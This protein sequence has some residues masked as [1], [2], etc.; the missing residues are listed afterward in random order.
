MFWCKAGKIDGDAGASES[1]VRQIPVLASSASRA[2]H[3][4]NN[5]QFG[6]SESRGMFSVFET[7][8]YW[9]SGRGAEKKP[10]SDRR[11]K[12]PNRRGRFSV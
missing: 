5:L 11:K 12:T 8:V 4:C 6:K 10:Q 1:L 3:I 9:R 2:K 7:E